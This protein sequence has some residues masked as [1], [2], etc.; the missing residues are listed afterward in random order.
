MIQD[1]PV[2]PS[3][4]VVSHFLV[5]VPDKQVNSETSYPTKSTLNAIPGPPECVS[6]NS[7]DPDICICHHFPS[8]LFVV[9]VQ[10]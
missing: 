10:Y 5:P 4:L 8:L 7:C 9:V 1:R 2:V 6:L 3:F